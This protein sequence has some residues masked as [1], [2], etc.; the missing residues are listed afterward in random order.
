MLKYIDDVIFPWCP[1]RKWS[2]W[3]KFRIYILVYWKLELVDKYLY[4]DHIY[5]IFISSSISI[6][7]YLEDLEHL[8][9]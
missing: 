4:I 3:W 7:I 5:K 8:T 6:Y 9:L 2:T 1:V